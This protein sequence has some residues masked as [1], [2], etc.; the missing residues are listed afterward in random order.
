MDK[1]REGHRVRG[2]FMTFGPKKR[3]KKVLTKK[4]KGGIV[5]LIQ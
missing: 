1:D 5:S 3:I 2:F 4:E